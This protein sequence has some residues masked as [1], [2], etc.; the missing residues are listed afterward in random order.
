MALLQRSESLINDLKF[1][2]NQVDP[3]FPPTY[4]VLDMHFEAY[5]KELQD[6]VDSMLNGP[7]MD[8]LL[9]E[10]PEAILFFSGFIQHCQQLVEELHFQD[11]F[12]MNLQI[13]RDCVLMLSIE[14]LRVLPKIYGSRW[15]QNFRKTLKN[16]RRIKITR[17]GKS[18]AISIE[19]KQ[20]EKGYLWNNFSWG[21]LWLY[22]I[23][24]RSNIGIS[25]RWET[26]W[27]CKKNDGLTLQHD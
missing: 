1:I 18:W 21:H 9:N 13:V 16:I 27:I 24:A 8:R 14:A 23:S 6:K 20:K 12:F 26:N 11:D 10:D 5:K 7:Q 3:C 15:V 4:K 25:E 22:D 17:S 2:K 19:N